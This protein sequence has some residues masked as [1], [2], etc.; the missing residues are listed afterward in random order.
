VSACRVGDLENLVGL[1]SREID[2][3]DARRVVAIDE[4]PAAVGNA[5][6]HRQLGMVRVVPRDEAERGLKHRL[7]F[8]I[9]TPA[10]LR[11]LREHWNHFQKTA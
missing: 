5:V 6:G 8:L 1:E 10:I 2:A 9:V 7:R 4:K 3:R 11:I